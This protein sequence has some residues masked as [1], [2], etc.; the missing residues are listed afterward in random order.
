MQNAELTIKRMSR[1]NW[2]FWAIVVL[3]TAAGAI[4]PISLTTTS[5]N[6]LDWSFNE[7][8][9]DSTGSPANIEDPQTAAA[10]ENGDIEL[11][12]VLPASIPLGCD[13]CFCTNN[14]AFDVEVDGKTI[15]SFQPGTSPLIGDCYGYAF[16]FIDVHEL[17]NKT[18]TI[19]AHLIYHDNS[20][21]FLYMAL[22]APDEYISYF[23]ETNL[24]AL[25]IAFAIGLIGLILVIVHSSIVR[26]SE[27][28]F[29][30]F[31]LGGSFILVG[32]WVSIHTLVPQLL[33]GPSVLFQFINYYFI[34][35]PVFLITSRRWTTSVPGTR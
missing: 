4:L 27:L 10:L 26:T 5:P 32:L 15:Y 21:R 11:S 1:L 13:F 8:W 24:T 20:T 12:K 2:L 30:L 16:H 6:T 22:G 14:I 3:L 9:V 7:G 33:I 34:V 31:A 29:N 23:V 35:F 17:T 25:G 18:L 19:N 28:D